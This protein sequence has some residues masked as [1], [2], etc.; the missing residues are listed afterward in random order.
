MSTRSLRPA[1]LAAVLSCL[2]A[3]TSPARAA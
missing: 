1:A 2:L 3:G